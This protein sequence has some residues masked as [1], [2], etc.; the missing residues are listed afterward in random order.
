MK[1]LYSAKKH[2]KAG[3]VTNSSFC[4]TAS[5]L[6]NIVHS[7]K[8][9]HCLNN[10]DE[11]KTKSSFITV[12][13]I[14][15][16]M[17]FARIFSEIFEFFSDFFAICSNPGFKVQVLSKQQLTEIA[18]GFESLIQRFLGQKGG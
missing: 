13:I 18:G 8:N 14:N 16:K 1:G 11:E 15:R 4:E 3:V 2:K 9:L 6:E 5:H 17:S 12:L 7:Y 10:Q